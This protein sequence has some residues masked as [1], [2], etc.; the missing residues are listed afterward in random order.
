MLGWTK[1][2]SACDWRHQASLYDV[3]GATNLR[4]YAVALSSK[5]LL[6]NQCIAKARGMNWPRSDC[7]AFAWSKGKQRGKSGRRVTD[8]PLFACIVIHKCLVMVHDLLNQHQAWHA[9]SQHCMYGGTKGY[10][11]GLK[12]IAELCMLD[13]CS[14]KQLPYKHH[15][16]VT[17]WSEINHFSD[18]LLSLGRL[19]ISKRLVLHMARTGIKVT[20][21]TYLQTVPSLAS[22]SSCEMIRRPFPAFLPLLP[23]TQKLPSH[24]AKR[25]LPAAQ[26]H[27]FCFA[28][29]ELER[30]FCNKMQRG[31]RW[32]WIL[33]LWASATE[34]SHCN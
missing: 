15:N 26:A 25:N 33:H 22:V 23:P 20:W 27:P 14:S 30:H 16:I 8:V 10:L 18:W 7:D 21:W 28:V 9:A 34:C 12:D 1:W 32:A 31:Q 11:C 13:L 2:V 3:H 6:S 4:A 19:Q 24:N 5:T 17:V 29:M